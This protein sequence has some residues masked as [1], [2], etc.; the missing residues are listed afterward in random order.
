[1]STKKY[2][3]H[4]KSRLRRLVVTLPNGEQLQFDDQKDLNEWKKEYIASLPV[5]EVAEV[6][7]DVE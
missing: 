6:V 7:E 5:K 4:Q 1:M 2:E 3:I